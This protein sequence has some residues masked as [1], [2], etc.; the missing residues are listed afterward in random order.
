MGKDIELAGFKKMEEEP[1]SPRMGAA[2]YQWVDL[3][4]AFLDTGY[5]RMSKTYPTENDCARAYHSA[6][7]ASYR[8]Y[9]GRMRVMKR[10]D[11]LILER[12]DGR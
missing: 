5:K 1:D 10:G 11:T 7:A 3:F 4:D 12:E 2:V 8:Y 9:V 6:Y